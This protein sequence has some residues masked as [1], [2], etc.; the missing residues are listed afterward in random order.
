ML[1]VRRRLPE[2]AG[3]K[4][5]FPKNKI[6]IYREPRQQPCSRSQGFAMPSEICQ[7]IAPPPCTATAIQFSYQ[8]ALQPAARNAPQY[9][10][11]GQRPGLRPHK[12]P[13]SPE[14]PLGLG[15]L[16]RSRRA[17]P[18]V[19]WAGISLPLRGGGNSTEMIGPSHGIPRTIAGPIARVNHTGKRDQT[20]IT[21]PNLPLSGR[22][23]PIAPRR[24]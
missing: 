4:P 22:V 19:A 7:A 9:A 14:G 12:H 23:S 11:P 21:N 13:P 2:S 18:T 8:V 15:Q 6:F 1:T 3:N 10:N 24:T 17:T 16:S 5:P 20:R